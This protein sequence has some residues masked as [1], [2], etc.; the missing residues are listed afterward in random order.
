MATIIKIN[1]EIQTQISKVV[2]TV[3]APIIRPSYFI[4][5]GTSNL[6]LRYKLDEGTAIHIGDTT[7]NYNATMSAAPTWITGKSGTG[8]ALSFDGLNDYIATD[9]NVTFGQNTCTFCAWIKFGTNA[10]EKIIFELTTNFRSANGAIILTYGFSTPIRLIAGIY[11][12]GDYNAY[13]TGITPGE[14]THVAVVF[15]N[16]T[17][18]S[19]YK[20]YLDG[21]LVDNTVSASARTGS[22]N[23]PTNRI[24]IG[25]R[26]N[27]VLPVAADMDD[28]RFYNRELALDEI[29]WVRDH[30]D[31]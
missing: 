2:G 27:S 10:T 31:E 13:I 25:S 16:S 29:I 28:I 3:I 14:W 6:L 15:D 19:P 18:T 17:T 26:Y 1:T 24:F 20:F 7:G 30:P 11:N 4:G 23:I 22:G 21:S 12:G 9:G 5:P 8:G